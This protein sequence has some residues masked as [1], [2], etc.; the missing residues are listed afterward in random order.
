MVIPL[1]KQAADEQ[2]R[3][4]HETLRYGAAWAEDGV[5][6]VDARRALRALLAHAPLRGRAPLPSSLAVDAELVVSELVTNALR[7]APGIC[8]LTL[9]LTDS[10]LLI[11]VW[12]G[13]PD[14]PLLKKPDRHRIG[15]H[16]LHL[17]HSI[18]DR[19]VVT[20]RGRGKE[21]TACLRLRLP[22]TSALVSVRQR[23]DLRGA[24]PHPAARSDSA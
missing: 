24:A 20:P 21:V 22:T 14:A 10:D 7:H 4:E 16:G 1:M 3:H 15:G 11:S 18:C 19:V 9:R 6:A 12:D 13:S 23:H 5:S 17:V 2:G 8:G